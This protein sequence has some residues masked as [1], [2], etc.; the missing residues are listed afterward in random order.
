MKNDEEVVG[1][2]VRIEYDEQ[3]DKLLLVFEISNLKYKQDIKRR[4]NQ[5]IKF[6][7]VNQFLIKVNDE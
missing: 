5:D 2:A 6:K 1:E 7:I 4:W 3:N